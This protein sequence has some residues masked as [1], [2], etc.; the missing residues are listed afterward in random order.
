MSATTQPPSTSQIPSPHDRIRVAAAAAVTPDTVLRAYR[1]AP[2]R[3][4]V[5]ARILAAARDLG[6][7]APAVVIAP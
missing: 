6:L 4:G 5:A 1:G 3:S 7:P 2:V